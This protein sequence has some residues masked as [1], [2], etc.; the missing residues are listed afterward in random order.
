MS[1]PNTGKQAIEAAS[2]LFSTLGKLPAPE[3]VLFEIQRLN[4][5]MERIMPDLSKMT[6]ALEGVTGQDIRSLS[7]AI[8]G[9]KVSEVLLVMNDVN[10]TINKLYE[11]LWGKK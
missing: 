7:M 10:S 6:H 8:Q 5:N 9:I 11:R 4:N 1:M 2:A 3:K